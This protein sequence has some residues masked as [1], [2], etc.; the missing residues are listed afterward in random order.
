[1]ALFTRLFGRI[2]ALLGL[3]ALGASG[4]AAYAFGR[5]QVV[6]AI[7]RERLAAALEAHRAL[8]AKYAR[9]VSETA[10]TELEVDAE[11][12]AVVVRTVE[13]EL[14]RV[15][16]EVDPRGEVHV[17]Y[18]VI[19]GRLHVRRVYDDATPPRAATV[20]DPRLARVDWEAPQVARGL[21]VYR[22]GLTPGRW[23]VTTT[24][25]GA[26]DLVRAED[27]PSELASPPPVRRFEE[28]EREVERQVADISALE[29][30]SRL[31]ARLLP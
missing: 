13:G 20:I 27:A 21:S 28:V 3:V 5:T 19:D 17:D 24:G 25:N 10:V 11:G 8:R 14:A 12:V 2:L 6:E 18:V 26:L 31:G 1:M 30:L 15:D 16:T 9:A 7:Y 23:R 29:V 4:T 22:G